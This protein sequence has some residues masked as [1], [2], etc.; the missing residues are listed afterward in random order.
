M[1]HIRTEEGAEPPFY[2]TRGRTH[3]EG[4]F[5]VATTDGPHQGHWSLALDPVSADAALG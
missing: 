2:E 3:L 4:Y 1:L 5:V